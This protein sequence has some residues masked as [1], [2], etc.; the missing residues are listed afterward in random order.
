MEMELGTSP[1]WDD[2]RG[3]YFSWK[4]L[5][6]IGLTELGQWWDGRT[7]FNVA[8]DCRK[9]GLIVIDEDKPNAFT[10][11]VSAEGRVLPDTYWVRTRKVAEGWKKHFYF[12]A[13]EGVEPR[14]WTGLL[15]PGVDVRWA[16]Y[17]VAPGS[18]HPDDGT[19][20][21]DG[22]EGVSPV[23]IP[24]WL[25]E[26]LYQPSSTL[27][28]HASGLPEGPSAAR[29]VGDGEEW[30]KGGPIAQGN[31][32]PNLFAAAR[33]CASEGVSEAEALAVLVDINDNRLE[34]KRPRDFLAAKVRDTY[35][36]RRQYIEIQDR[37]RE[38]DPDYQWLRESL[39]KPRKEWTIP[40][41]EG[42][43]R[44]TPED[45]GVVKPP[46]TPPPAIPDNAEKDASKG[47]VWSGRFPLRPC[48]N[49][50][51]RVKIHQN[52]SFHRGMVS[53]RK[54]PN[55]LW[56]KAN[57][58][59]LQL[60]TNTE[61]GQTL[62]RSVFVKDG[63]PNGETAKK[64]HQRAGV[65]YAGIKL[66][67]S[68][69][70]VIIAAARIDWAKYDPEEWD[71]DK[72]LDELHALLAETLSWRQDFTGEWK[73]K[74]EAIEEKEAER[75]EEAL[76]PKSNLDVGPAIIHAPKVMQSAYKAIDWRPWNPGPI[77]FDRNPLELYRDLKRETDPVR[78]GILEEMKTG[79]GMIAFN[80]LNLSEL[81]S[82]P[83][84]IESGPDTTERND[85]KEAAE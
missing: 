8:I 48:V 71:R 30:W 64:N 82:G 66:K 15:P 67:E 9:S 80:P 28:D 31:G 21:P 69:D 70:L 44:L 24:A 26:A 38:N 13:P 27:S 22:P 79:D 18:R 34:H 43:Q 39:S 2:L 42:T 68:G 7:P 63:K 45:R 40:W 29:F 52:R 16:G 12:L 46:P 78:R 19:I 77:P 83:V 76:K 60:E 35:R 59:A 81:E 65:S 14:N 47:I 84:A 51:E 5:S 37:K 41:G 75:K 25:F 32:E 55:C 4:A 49:M 72:L 6:A 23:P 11:W 20:R 33:R 85:S 74:P 17:V 57:L 56:N 3:I 58:F 61:E 50:L 36:S 54:C 73:T 1:A 53:C 62:Y 10:D